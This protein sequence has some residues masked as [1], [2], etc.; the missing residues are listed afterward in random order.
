MKS[1]NFPASNIP[2]RTDGFEV[3]PN[4]QLYRQKLYGRTHGSD[5]YDDWL[6]HPT[7]H[8]LHYYTSIMDLHQFGIN[9]ACHCV[10]QMI[11]TIRAIGLAQKWQRQTLG[12]YKTL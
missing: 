6:S 11:G 8:I 3:I 1:Y 5:L 12:R 2:P 9:T 10:T 4:I 7:T